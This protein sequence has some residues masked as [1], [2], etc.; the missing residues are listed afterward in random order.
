MTLFEKNGDIT[1]IPAVAKEV[2]DVTG[3]G[4]TVIGTFAL[5]VAAGASSK[6]A[7]VLANRSAGVAVGKVGTATVKPEELLRVL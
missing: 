3:A 2:Y 5:A 4:D 7:A 1:D 6:E